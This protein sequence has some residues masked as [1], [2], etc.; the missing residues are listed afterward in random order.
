[1]RC[2]DVMEGEI[3]GPAFYDPCKNY[4]ELLALPR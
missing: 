1:M 4:D 2:S 3:Y